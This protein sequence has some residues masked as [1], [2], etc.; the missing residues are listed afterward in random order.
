VV[1][2]ANCGGRVTRFMGAHERAP[3]TL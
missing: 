2:A 3:E 1:D